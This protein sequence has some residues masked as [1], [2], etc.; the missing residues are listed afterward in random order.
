MHPASNCKYPRGECSSC[1]FLH[2]NHCLKTLI[3]AHTVNFY[4]QTNEKLYHASGPSLWYFYEF[5]F[6][7]LRKVLPFTSLLKLRLASKKGI[8]ECRFFACFFFQKILTTLLLRLSHV[9]L[10]EFP[11]YKDEMFLCIWNP[12]LCFS[13]L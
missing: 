4:T 13:G 12:F 2:T 6:S 1:Q 7:R 8:E 9:E 3:L 11:Y 10:M 5:Y